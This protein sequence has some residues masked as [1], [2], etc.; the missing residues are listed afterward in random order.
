[1]P[2]QARF[3]VGGVAAHITQR[4]HNGDVCFIRQSDYLLYL[5]HLRE[6]SEKHGCAVH[7]YC[8]M[9]NHVHLLLTP[10]TESAC[11]NLMRDLGQRYVQH[12]N[13]TYGRKGTLW[14]GRY[15][16]NVAQSARYVIG[17]YRYIERNPVVAHMV[18]AAADYPWS[19]AAHNT[20][21]REDPLVQPHAEYL[22]ISEDPQRRHGAYSDLLSRPLDADLVREIRESRDT[23]YP[24]A[25]ESFKSE[26]AERLGRRTEAGRAGRPEKRLE[27]KSGSD[28]DFFSISGDP[29]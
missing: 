28:P 10:E 7:A 8:L 24:L 16:A 13:K 14:Q 18:K 12:F 17:C 5:L 6:L 9:T 4:G 2:R 20:G 26:L 15:W 3:V 19:S 1:M 27:K 29:T 11:S 21:V 25:S 23:G 22:A